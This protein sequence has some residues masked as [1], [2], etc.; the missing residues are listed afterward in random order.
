VVVEVLVNETPMVTA[1]EIRQVLTNVRAQR[2]TPYLRIRSVGY[3]D[4]ATLGAFAPVGML[5]M[6]FGN[7]ISRQPGE[8]AAPQHLCVGRRVLA[9]ATMEVAAPRG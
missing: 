9:E 3:H 7:G 1:P 5:F 8:W 2:K 4:A 6:P